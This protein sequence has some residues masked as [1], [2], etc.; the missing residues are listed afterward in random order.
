MIERL[1][2]R[3]DAADQR[4]LVAIA[5]ALNATGAPDALP[6][7]R[8]ATISQAVRLALAVTADAVERGEAEAFLAGVADC[9]AK[10]S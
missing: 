1:G 7:Q 2:L 5:A 9:A 3:L 4:R 6:W 8:K 10:S